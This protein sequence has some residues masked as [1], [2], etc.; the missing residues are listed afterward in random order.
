MPAMLDQKTGLTT[1]ASSPPDPSLHPDSDS[2]RRFGASRKKW[3]AEEEDRSPPDS[4]SLTVKP[5]RS[6]NSA[7]L[8]ASTDSPSP[9]PPQSPTSSSPRP[10]SSPQTSISSSKETP[11]EGRCPRSK[12]PLAPKP[13]ISSTKQTLGRHSELP[14]QPEEPAAPPDSPPLIR[15]LVAPTEAPPPPVTE[16]PSPPLTRA[17]LHNLQDLPDSPTPPDAPTATPITEEDT[18]TAD[19]APRKIEDLPEKERSSTPE[20]KTVTQIK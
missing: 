20:V 7:P 15:E 6:R 11:K 16:R 19:L 14:D 18:E 10:P 2:M 5:R 4:P 9:K 8:R 13:R 12:P 1:S 3:E 17:E